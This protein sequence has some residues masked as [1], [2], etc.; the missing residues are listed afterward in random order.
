ML[1][2]TRWDTAGEVLSPKRKRSL[3]ALRFGQ[4]SCTPLDEAA[5]LH[6]VPEASGKLHCWHTSS[7]G[8]FMGVL[9][10][11]AACPDQEGGGVV[12][13]SSHSCAA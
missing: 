6:A 4:G 12:F 13:T 3:Q 2:Q 1:L 7:A 9:V 10:A 11:S 5:A 8:G